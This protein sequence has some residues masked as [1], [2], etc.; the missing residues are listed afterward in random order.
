M[1]NYAVYIHKNKI[2]GKVYVGITR[3]DVN[4]RW[5]NGNGYYQ[6][7]HFS[8]AIKKYGWDS[9]EHIV[10]KTGL[11][12]DD[13][14]NEER[15][16]IKKYRS[17]DE[18]Y[19]YNK[20]SGGEKPAFGVKM[21]KETRDKMRAAHIGK[22]KPD[23]FAEKISAAKK[24]KPNGKTGKF[25]KDSGNAH[26]IIQIDKDGNV[27]GEFYGVYEAARKLGYKTPGRIGDVCR[28]QR[29]TAY[30]YIWKYIEG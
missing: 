30:G 11:T 9:F 10:I 3:Q 16:L 21:S 12:K 25:G 22:K 28:G 26:R 23:G 7:K 4:R 15:R 19:G 2:N 29:K 24:G 27:I 17:N 18:R 13:A 5:R 14:C 1:N 8:R 6:N 20:S